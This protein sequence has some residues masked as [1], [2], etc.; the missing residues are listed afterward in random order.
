MPAR[1]GEAVGDIRKAAV[2]DGTLHLWFGDGTHRIYSKRRA[3]VA[4][5]LPDNAVPIAVGG[6][7]KGA[8]LFAIVPRSVA[9][10]LVPKMPEPSTENANANAED[11]DEDT[12]TEVEEPAQDDQSP[13]PQP[14]PQTDFSLVRLDGSRWTFDRDMPESFAPSPTTLLTATGQQIIVVFALENGD[15][16]RFT[17]SPIRETE[18]TSTQSIDELAGEEIVA[19]L[20]LATAPVLIARPLSDNIATP[21]IFTE[22]RWTRQTPL[23]QPDAETIDWSTAAF[24]YREDHIVAVWATAD[25]TVHSADWSPNGGAAAAGAVRVRPFTPGPTTQG[26]EWRRIMLAY[27]VL[28]FVMAAVFFRRRTSVIESIKLPPEYTLVTHSR[29][30]TAFAIDVAIFSPAAFWVYYSLLADFNFN[31]VS[32]RQAV[33][34]DAEI[35][36]SLTWR[37]TSCLLGFIA[38]AILFETLW[39]AT[40]GKK[41]MGMRV[42]DESAK[43]CAFRKILVR[44]LLRGVELFPG[45]DLLPTLVLVFLTRNRQRLGDLIANTIVVRKADAPTSRTN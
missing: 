29:R 2:S 39:S 5:S 43:P 16:P 7:N 20:N 41:L 30:L 32:L 4:A 6:S 17:T 45:L 34:G 27:I 25:H 21:Y 23:E 26:W 18:W 15:A 11:N 14:R 10:A 24:A 37:W 28:T 9:L 40:P 31:M 13:P 44:N 36:R 19:L 3:A 42:L 8:S 1:A 12:E 22:D 35:A 33:P 38:Y